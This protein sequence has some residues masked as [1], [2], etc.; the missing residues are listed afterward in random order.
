MKLVVLVLVVACSQH[1]YSPPTQAYALDPIR[2]LNAGGH[3]VDVDLSRHQ[4]VFDPAIDA[5]AGRVRTGLGGD[6]EMSVEGGVMVVEDHGQAQGDRKLYSGRIGYRENPGH[7][8]LSWFA[9]VGGGFSPSGG[10]FAAGDVGVAVGYENCLLVPVAQAST[11]LSVPLAA[12]PVDVTVDPK[13]PMTSVAQNTVGGTLRV[14]LRLS[15][16]P[17]AC[18]LGKPVPWLHAGLDITAL[19]DG[20]KDIELGGIGIGFELPW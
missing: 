9:G 7:G 3:A 14:G 20:V 10:T 16:G 18:R 11:F 2:A 15:L 4:A 5:A 19:T 12:M 17:A 6:R 1:V 13:S 8:A